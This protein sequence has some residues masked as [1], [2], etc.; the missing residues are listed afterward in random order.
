MGN[1]DMHLHST[2]SDGTDSPAQLLE[3]LRRSSIEIFSLTDHDDCLGCE[4]IESFLM[5]GDPAF[6]PGVEL[7]AEEDGRKYHILGYAYDTDSPV[8]SNLAHRVHEI[9]MCKVQEYFSFLESEFHFSFSPEDIRRIQSLP[10]P[11][12]PHIGNLMVK[13]GYVPSMP[14]GIRNYLDLHKSH[15]RDIS[16]AEAVKS[17]LDAKGIP[18]LAHGIYGDGRQSLD[19]EELSYRISYLHSLGLQGV[20]CYYSRYTEAEQRLTRSICA[21]HHLFATAGSDYHGEN[22]PVSIGEHTLKNASDD[23]DVLRFLEAC[24]LS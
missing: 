1:I 4:M 3:K 10:N 23:P 21:E 14:V 2:V 9:R 17:I 6:I 18:V 7:S 12:K 5:P 13:Y 11:G 16:P 15:Y 8:I 19:A 20:E 22:K 24:G